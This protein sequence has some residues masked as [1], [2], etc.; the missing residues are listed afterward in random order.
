MCVWVERGEEGVKSQFLFFSAY[1]TFI[2]SFLGL[3][4][5]IFSL[6][7]ERGQAEMVKHGTYFS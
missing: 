4:L 7:L 3:I 2:W 5:N 6:I 1:Q